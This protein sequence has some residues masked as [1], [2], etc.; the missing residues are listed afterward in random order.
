MKSIQAGI[1]GWQYVCCYFYHYYYYL[2]LLL[3]FLLLLPLL[4]LHWPLASYDFD[5]DFYMHARQSAL[6]YRHVVDDR[7]MVVRIA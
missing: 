1:A 2:L 4:Q 7:V 5:D 6:S 3:L